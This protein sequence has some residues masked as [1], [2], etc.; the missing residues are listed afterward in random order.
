V[1]K[2]KIAM[3]DNCFN[4]IGVTEISGQPGVSV[5]VPWRSWFLLL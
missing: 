2:A 3:E 1:E 5:P 4:N